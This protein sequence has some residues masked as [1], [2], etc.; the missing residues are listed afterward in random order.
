MPSILQKIVD[1]RR[2][3]LA[4]SPLKCQAASS[5]DIKF[6]EGTKAVNSLA[7]QLKTVSP[8][9]I[10]EC[11]KASP[12]KGLMANNYQ[13]DAIAKSYAPFA[14]AVSVLTEPDY[15]QGDLAHLQAV[16]QVVDLPIL[17]KDFIVDESQIS[18]AHAAGANVILLMLSVVDDAFYRQAISLTQR[19]GLEVITEVINEQELDRAIK[20][21]APIIGINNRNLHTLETDLSVTERLAPLIPNDRLIIA[22]SGIY[23]RHDLLRLAPLVNGFLVG[24][25]LML[26][27]DI[28]LALRRLMFG[29]VKVC[30]ITNSE[31]LTAIYQAGASYAGFIFVEKSSRYIEPEKAKQLIES[32][33]AI[34]TVGVVAN[35]DTQQ[36]V[37]LAKELK[38]DVLQL[39]GDESFTQ[40]SEL[41]Q[42]LQGTDIQVWKAV[43][44]SDEHQ[45]YPSLSE[46]PSLIERWINVGVQ[47]L[48]IDSPKIANAPTL[49]L[50]AFAED[51]RLMLAGG[52]AVTE[53]LYQ[54]KK[55]QAGIDI[56]SAL[57]QQPGKKCPQKLQTFFNQLTVKT[58]QKTNKESL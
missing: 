33:P 27:A 35:A 44:V 2:A 46:L 3:R 7:S 58:K 14:A 49:D 9:L 45:A 29:E 57:E 17:C 56:C 6:I 40:V 13:P 25:S 10:L 43:A 54:H 11:K 20:L 15:F 21:N 32:G 26:E 42:A 4:N 1:S 22:E 30:G 53:S 28:D 8:G 12:S 51:A 48:L 16:R 47:K 31:D 52:R 23:T 38:L 36:F 18:A 50:S 39:H 41:I 5:G 19:L 55:L 24:S 37:T 34:K